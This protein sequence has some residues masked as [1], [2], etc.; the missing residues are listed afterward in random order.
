MNRMGEWGK[1]ILIGGIRLYQIFLS[2]VFPP[3]CRYYPTCSEYAREAI[4]TAGIGKGLWLSLRRVLRCHPWSRGGYDP[5]RR[6]G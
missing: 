4:A 5:V 3:A 6:A 1:R 2:P